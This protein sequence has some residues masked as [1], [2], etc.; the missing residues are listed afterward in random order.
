M[1]TK[2]VLVAMSGGVDS[3]VAALLLKQQ[4]YNVIGATMQI[5]PADL[6]DP[7]GSGGCCSLSAVNDARRVADM[8]DIPYYVFNMRDIFQKNVI[9]YFVDEYTNGRTPNPCIACNRHL[10]FDAF[11]NKAHTIGADFIATGHYSKI[12]YNSTYNR[13]VLG[14]AKD[15]NK[16]QTYVLYNM[17]QEQLKHTLFPLSEYVKPEVRKLAEDF[18]M[19]VAHKPESQE[20]CF[21]PDNDYRKFLKEK[22]GINPKPG[23]FISTKGDILGEHKG[24]P[25]YTIGQ[26]KGLG[27]ALGYPIYVVSIDVARNQVVLGCEEEVTRGSLEASCVNYVA[28]DELI[29]PMT[30]AAKIRYKSPEVPA[31]IFPIEGGKIKVVFDDPQKAITP[32]Q[33]VVFYKDDIVLAGGTID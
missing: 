18:G 31:T 20:I 21:V 9:D 7:Q 5:W 25:Y 17:T 1:T 11:L 4:G 32:G 16:D 2:T 30:C 12:G 15:L 22:A 19:L 13:Y 14:K 3:S 29:K 27:I 8:L 23:Y 28:L 6:P 26:R 33:A 24:I 10:K